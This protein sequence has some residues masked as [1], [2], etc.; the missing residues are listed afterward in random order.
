MV[1]NAIGEGWEWGR[2][3]GIRINQQL[4]PL[5]EKDPF[6]QWDKI[7]AITHKYKIKQ[8]F[9]ARKKSRGDKV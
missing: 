7:K 6:E 8:Y 3:G 1:Q 2:N 5:M 4:E 9:L